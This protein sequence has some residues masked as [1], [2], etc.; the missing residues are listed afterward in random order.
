[1]GYYENAF[2][3][4]TPMASTV[5]QPMPSTAPAPARRPINWAQLAWFAGLI[6]I[7]YLSILRPLVDQWM[8]DDDMGHGGF[9]PVIAAYIAWQ[10]K[11]QILAE[12]FRPSFWGLLPLLWGAF[13]SYVANLGAELFLSR[14]AILF[15]IAGAVWLVCGTRVLKI[16]A[17]PL[18]LLIFMVPLPSVIYNAITMP[19]QFFAS[20]VAE[21]VLN[22]LGYPV[23]R[24][25][26][27]LELANNKLNVVEACS[28]IRSLMTLTFLSLVYGYLSDDK[29]WMRGVLLIG[30]I[31]IAIAANAFRVTLT[32]IIS[33]YN[34]DWAEGFFH[35]AEGW[36]IFMVAFA[37]L[38]VLHRLV[39]SFYAML[40]RARTEQPLAA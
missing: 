32:G 21:I 8:T 7:G 15:T 40:V 25:G 38:F 14:S 18:G 27:V 31:P 37:M 36:V 6:I 29:P 39:N 17:F 26:N 28:G 4:L 22:I 20:S 13:Q 35:T 23:L 24:E 11:D 30:V 19:L 33:E 12:P 16:L 1:M 9:V 2:H 10:R 5:T 3:E 34:K